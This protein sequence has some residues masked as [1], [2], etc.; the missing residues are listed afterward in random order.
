MDREP[1]VTIGSSDSPLRGT[2]DLDRSVKLKLKPLKLPVAF[3]DLRTVVSRFSSQELRAAA[4][5]G[6]DKPVAILAIAGAIERDR[7]TAAITG[8]PIRGQV[9][10]REGNILR[11]AAPATASALAKYVRRQSSKS[12]DL[13]LF[14]RIEVIAGQLVLE[15]PEPVPEWIGRIRPVYEAHYKTWSAQLEAWP[16]LNPNCYLARA[17]IQN[18]YRR[19]F[20]DRFKEYVQATL[21]DL[22]TRGLT[23]QRSRRIAFGSALQRQMLS[24]LSK[25]L[26]QAHFPEGDGDITAAHEGLEFIGAVAATHARVARAVRRERAQASRRTQTAGLEPS[27]GSDYPDYARRLASTLSFELTDEQLIAIQEAL[28]DLDAGKPMHRVLSGEV[29]SGKTVVFCLIAKAVLLGGGRVAILVPTLPLL[30]QTS[31]RL[32]EYLPEFRHAVVGG[33]SGEIPANAT[34]CVGTTALRSRAEEIFD[35][36]V[37]DEQQRFSRDQ[38]ESLGHRRAHIYESTATP[39][40]R[41][42]SL[43]LSRTVRVSSLKGTQVTKIVHTRLWPTSQRAELFAVFTHSAEIGEKIMVVYPAIK[44][45]EG[46]PGTR[47]AAIED[48]EGLWRKRFGRRVTVVLGSGSMS[49]HQQAAGLDAFRSGEANILI[50]TTVIEVGIDIPD[51]R[52]VVIVQAERFGI[53][54]LHQLRGRAARGGGVGFCDLFL[55]HPVDA[56]GMRRLE[57]FCDEV[58]GSRLATRDMQQ[59]GSGDTRKVGNRQKGAPFKNLFT[60]RDLSPHMIEQAC[61]QLYDSYHGQSNE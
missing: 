60:K 18:T 50:A 29:G 1:E 45:T 4:G 52:R 24:K 46:P 58:D 48:V 27:A 2:V 26:W 35:L 55:P 44:S 21:V 7:P 12:E 61:Q 25:L 6:L 13:T 57:V 34:L 36:V 43:T 33:A 3:E 16:S 14:G 19:E 56:A 10:D 39:I 23:T 15:D 30:D 40:P 37:I 28:S 11:F 20:R 54:Q 41:T 22:L 9:K 49:A 17:H 5:V 8:R 47:L 32:S 53:Q 42:Q 59:R 51:V 38:R 31:L